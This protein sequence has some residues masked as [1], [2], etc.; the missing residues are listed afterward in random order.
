MYD[1]MHEGASDEGMRKQ[2]TPHCD[3]HVDPMLVACICMGQ[4]AY[5]SRCELA[6]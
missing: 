3:G 4:D 2:P 5:I 6:A 1:A